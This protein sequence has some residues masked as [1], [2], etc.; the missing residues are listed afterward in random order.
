MT[1]LYFSL[2]IVL[3]L[4]VVVGLLRIMWGPTAADRMMAAQ[5]FGTCGVAILLLLAHGLEQV[6]VEDVALVFALLSAV[7]TVA[8]VRRAWHQ[9]DAEA[10][11]ARDHD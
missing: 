3:L 5:L 9:E 8:F 11:S 4:L 7:S 10:S 1:T 2:A 6:V